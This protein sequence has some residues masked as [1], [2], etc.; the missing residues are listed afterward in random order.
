MKNSDGNKPITITPMANAALTICMSGLIL[1]GYF[2]GVMTGG[3]NMLLLIITL[4]II[5]LLYALHKLTSKYY[6]IK[7]KW[8]QGMITLNG[9]SH[10]TKKHLFT[11]E[12]IS[13]VP[14]FDVI[15]DLHNDLSI[16]V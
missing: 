11:I 6:N 15:F 1:V 3:P 16:C 13:N 12:N 8:C 7:I 9:D 2:V 4:L 5:T 10:F 14:L